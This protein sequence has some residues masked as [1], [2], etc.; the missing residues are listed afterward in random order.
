MYALQ[1]W[2]R[3]L[4]AIIVFLLNM[5]PFIINLVRVFIRIFNVLSLLIPPKYAFVQYKPAL[6][7]PSFSPCAV[8][9]PLS[10]SLEIQ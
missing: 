10:P 2:K 6:I 3:Y 4:L 1:V 8:I 7:G 5:V 9:D